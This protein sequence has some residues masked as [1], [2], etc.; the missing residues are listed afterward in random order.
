MKHLKKVKSLGIETEI[1]INHISGREKYNALCDEYTP[2]NIEEFMNQLR[3]TDMCVLCHPRNEIGNRKD[4]HRLIQAM[5]LGIP[6]ITSKTLA[7]QKTLKEVGFEQLACETE[8]EIEAAVELIKDPS[9]REQISVTFR[10]YAWEHYSP[11][12]RA[13]EFYNLIWRNE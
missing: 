12:K 10:K 3:E 8:Q 11:Q 13:E 9:T 7:F 2:W 1:I 4:N 5:S 6:T